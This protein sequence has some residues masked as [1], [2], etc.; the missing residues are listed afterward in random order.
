[1]REM[2]PCG[3]TTRIAVVIARYARPAMSRVWSE[4]AKLEQWL[5]VELAVLDAWA[6]V[7]LVPSAS[8]RAVRER[9]RVPSPAQVAERERVTNHDVARSSTRSRQTSART[10]A[11]S[12]TGSRRRT[13]STPH[14]R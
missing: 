8:A 3:A 7:G 10:A 11:G 9:A 13:S 6:E 14:C 4:E 5:A 2:A 12:T 1:M